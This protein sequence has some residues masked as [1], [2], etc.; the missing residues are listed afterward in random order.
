MV[1][2]HSASGVFF[3]RWNMGARDRHEYVGLHRF[4]D[5][6][7]YLHGKSRALALRAAARRA[8]VALRLSRA[9]SVAVLG[10]G[11]GARAAPGAVGRGAAGHS[12]GTAGHQ[13]E[14]RKRELNSAVGPICP[15]GHHRGRR[16]RCSGS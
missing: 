8:G 7:E 11:P 9:P 14:R 1:H 16:P 5:A 13:P 2:H 10:H 4:A 12:Q 3:S 15:T 6:G